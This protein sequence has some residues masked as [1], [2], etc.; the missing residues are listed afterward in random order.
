[1]LAT[2]FGNR[3]NSGRKKEVVVLIKPTIIRSEQDWEAQTRKV[4]T[5]LD[6]MD[7]IRA[8]VIRI[9]GGFA[10]SGTKAPVPAPSTLAPAPASAK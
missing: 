3:A 1:L 6:E 9:D 4:S 5:A 10:A 7:T 8:R 2:L